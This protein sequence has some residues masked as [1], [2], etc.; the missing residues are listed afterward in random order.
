M[1]DNIQEIKDE[2]NAPQKR[3]DK[4]NKKTPP[5]TFQCETDSTIEFWEEKL[6]D[7]TE[8]G[9][10]LKGKTWSKGSIARLENFKTLGKLT[11]SH[12]LK[13]MNPRAKMAPF[14]LPGWG[15]QPQ[16]EVVKISGNAVFSGVATL[17]SEKY[18]KKGK[19]N[20]SSWLGSFASGSDEEKDK[21]R[22]EFKE[23]FGDKEF[24]VF[25]EG[26]NN[27]FERSQ[28]LIL[29]D[30]N[31][32]QIFIPGPAGYILATPLP[33]IDD[34]ENTKSIQFE[35]PIVEGEKVK[36]YN[37]FKQTGF[38]VQNQNVTA[39]IPKVK[40]R[41]LSHIEDPSTGFERDLWRLK[42]NNSLIPT[43][44]Y[45]DAGEL[46]IIYAK[47]HEYYNV[48]NGPKQHD[49]KE[50]ITEKALQVIECAKKYVQ[51]L[52]DSYFSRFDEEVTLQ[53][54]YRDML[55]KVWIPE[56]YRVQ[57]T[58]SLRSDEF[59]KFLEMERLL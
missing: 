41:F 27:R 47:S 33:S 4:K 16:N 51:F 10:T 13:V 43:M 55:L 44:K 31:F 52:E 8:L 30:E 5:Q 9:K 46:L 37:E 28:E 38:V 53:P 22:L 48:Q 17:F 23:Y 11:G 26:F 45:E 20:P 34:M 24:A 56:K 12:S 32:P 2:G 6:K 59:S 57:V 19:N 29:W 3:G 39:K 58:T 15:N 54:D 21:L 36:F 42:F 50:Q 7:G 18:L 49:P 40:T 25:E 1:S 14:S 35:A